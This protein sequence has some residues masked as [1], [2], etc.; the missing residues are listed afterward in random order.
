MPRAAAPTAGQQSD[1]VGGVDPHLGKSSHGS[2]PTMMTGK[3]S[4]GMPT[5][6]PR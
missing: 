2:D 6:K 5:N 3:D 4:M 1:L